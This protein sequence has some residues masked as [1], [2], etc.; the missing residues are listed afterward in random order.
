MGKKEAYKGGG[1]CH[2]VNEK[3]KGKILVPAGGKSVSLKLA[4]WFRWL[5]YGRSTMSLSFGEGPPTRCFLFS[6]G[7]RLGTDVTF[8]TVQSDHV[9]PS[10][11]SN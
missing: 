9:H 2:G 10:P 7:F 6:L 5:V 1:T 11:G 4:S 3:R 8:L